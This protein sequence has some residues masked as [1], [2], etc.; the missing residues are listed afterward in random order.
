MTNRLFR[1]CAGGLGIDLSDSMIA[2]ARRYFERPPT[3]L[4]GVADATGWVTRFSGESDFSKAVCYGSFMYFPPER[5]GEFL[6]QLRQRFSSITRFFVGNLLNKSKIHDFLGPERYV[7][8]I[9]DD[10]TPPFGIWRTEAEFATLAGMAGWT[11]EFRR[12]P[13]EFY[14]SSY[15]YDAILT[16]ARPQ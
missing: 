8:G 13:A 1:S 12:M 5:V 11:V 9:E 3:R 4:F 2:I 10:H 6:T 15:R 7:S 14:G 16:P